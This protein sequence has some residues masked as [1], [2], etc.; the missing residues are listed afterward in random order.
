[1]LRCIEPEFLDALPP[2]DPGAIHSRRDLRRL[3]FWMGHSRI[4][5]RQ[6]RSSF[7]RKPARRLVD[8]GGGDGAFLLSVCQSLGPRWQGTQALI[9]DRHDLLSAQTRQAFAAAGWQVQVAQRDAMEFLEHKAAPLCE[10][11]VCNLVLHHFPDTALRR[12]FDFA[13]QTTSAFLAVEPRRSFLSLTVSKIVGII[14]CNS[15]TRHDAPASVVAGFRDFELS[16]LW[17]TTSAWRLEERPAGL[18]SHLF[19]ARRLLG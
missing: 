6:L 4:M 1:M 13:P 8:I 18:F 14:G 15:V 12:L 17:P 3:N 7:P 9:V 11:M 5:A 16:A 19:F 10:I 2:E